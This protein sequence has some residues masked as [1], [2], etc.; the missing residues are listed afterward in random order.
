MNAAR[1]EVKSKHFCLKTHGFPNTKH[2]Y[3][4]PP[5]SPR[6]TACSVDR[7]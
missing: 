4:K 3:E 7:K 6:S 2:L 1:F 5:N